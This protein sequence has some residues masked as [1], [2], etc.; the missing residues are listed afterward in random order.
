[1][2]IASLHPYSGRELNSVKP[3][4]NYIANFRKCL[5]PE[6]EN[7]MPVWNTELF[8]LYDNDPSIP[9]SEDE[10]NPARATARVMVDLGEGVLQSQQINAQQLIQRRLIPEGWFI[11]PS[12]CEILPNSTYVAYN[13]MARF[14]EAAKP[15]A[16]FKLDSGVIAYIYR[17]DGKLLAGLWNYQHK[18]DVKA[19]LSMFDMYDVH[20]NSIPAAKDMPVTDIPYFLKPGKLSDEAFTD[21]VKNL[22]IE[23]GI[24]VETQP[25]ARL[26]DFEGKKT[27]HV[28]LVS[29][30][31]KDQHVIAGFSGNGLAAMKSINAEIPARKTRVIAIPLREAASK[32]NDPEVQLFINGT[33]TRSKVKLH[34][35]LM[36]PAGTSVKLVQ[37]RNIQE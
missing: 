23:L 2:D 8:F 15:V 24:P 12:L 17:K 33:L 4:D 25:H 36:I 21:A 3:A 30:S 5:G 26:V 22:K 28:T 7:T 34:E 11:G 10:V 6:Y 16:K 20:G 13:A 9:H 27:L 18:K 37:S 31:G 35:G 19:D 1:M 29:G 32:K 14:L